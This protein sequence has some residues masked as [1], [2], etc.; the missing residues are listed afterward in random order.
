MKKTLLLAFIL[1]L[2]I[3]LF[4]CT[5]RRNEAQPESKGQNI[6]ESGQN[7]EANEKAVINIV[8]GFGKKLQEVSLQ[9]PKDVLEKSMKE[10]YGDF[11][12]GKLITAWISDPLNAP[13]RLTSSPWPD[14][15]EIVD[16]KKV[17]EDTYQ[18]NG[19]IIEI[20]S[21]EKAS[22]KAAAKRPITLTVKK[23]D[24]RWIIDDVTLGDYKEVG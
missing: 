4:G 1:L 20:T 3:S 13:G 5:S 10:S 7:D 19:E 9:A 17:S 23:S 2:S 8:E 24:N 6:E 22:G 12:S 18:V 14:R 15:I 21:T 16:I 11:V